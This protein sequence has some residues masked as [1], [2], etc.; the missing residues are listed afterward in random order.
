MHGGAARLQ[1]VVDDLEAPQRHAR[2]RPVARILVVVRAAE[3][4]EVLRGGNIHAELDGLLKAV[5]G[6]LAHLAAALA[7]GARLVEAHRRH[8]RRDRR[9]RHV[10]VVVPRHRN[11][12]HGRRVL[13][14][15]A[16]HTVWEI[17]R[18]ASADGERVDGGWVL[19]ANRQAHRVAVGV[20][21]RLAGDRVIRHRGDDAVD[22]VRDGRCHRLRALLALLAEAAFAARHGALRGVARRWRLAVALTVRVVRAQI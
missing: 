17:E 15:A 14:A 13:V 8:A 3:G 20:A 5:H 22:L 21:W 4:R 1:A 19:P 10:R 6:H 7:V 12:T 11:H 9:V 18:R 16:R 2:R